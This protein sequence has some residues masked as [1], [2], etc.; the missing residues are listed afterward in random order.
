M[1]PKGVTSFEISPSLT[2]T[3]PVS[4][5][6]ARA[7]TVGIDPSAADKSFVEF[8]GSCGRGKVRHFCGPVVE[9]K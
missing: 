6:S 5:A 1:P 3:I 4:I 9:V 8:E 2:P 7:T